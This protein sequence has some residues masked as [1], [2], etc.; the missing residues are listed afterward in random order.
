MS[1][2]GVFVDLSQ[3]HGVADTGPQIG[4]AIGAVQEDSEGIA[5]GGLADLVVFGG[6]DEGFDAGEAEVEG[7]VGGGALQGVLEVVVLEGGEAEGAFFLFGWLGCE[8]SGC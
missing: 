8:R 1:P 3:Q 4:P 6:G 5:V 7:A 2:I